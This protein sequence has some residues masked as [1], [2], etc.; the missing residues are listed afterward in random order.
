MMYA[1]I[2]EDPAGLS[3]EQIAELALEITESYSEAIRAARATGAPCWVIDETRD[4][5]SF[6]QPAKPVGAKDKFV[7]AAK[8]SAKPA[9][10]SGRVAYRSGGYGTRVTSGGVGASGHYCTGREGCRCPDCRA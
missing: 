6:N 3:P 7:P 8:R 4:T 9:K 1:V 10:T 2:A 5:Q